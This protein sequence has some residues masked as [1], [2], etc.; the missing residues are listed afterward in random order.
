MSYQFDYKKEDTIRSISSQKALSEF[1][2]KNAKSLTRYQ[3]YLISKNKYFSLS[4]VD[5]EYLDMLDWEFISMGISLSIKEMEEHAG[6]LNWYCISAFQKLTIAFIEKYKDYLSLDVLLG[7]TLLDKE[8]E[9][10]AQ[11]TYAE[12]ND[13]QHYI[14]WR[15]N[16]LNAKTFRPKMPIQQNA[17]TAIELPTDA[18]ISKMQKA[19]A[20]LWLDKLQVRYLYKNTIAELRDMLQKKCNEERNSNMDTSAA[21]SYSDMLLQRIIRANRAEVKDVETIDY[22]NLSKSELK[23]ILDKRHIRYFYKDTLEILRDRC[24]R[25]DNG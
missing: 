25:S 16:L 7:N 17:G 5:G 21:D 14:I 1:L 8:T 12:N 2:A 11:K 20:K 6:Y 24:R 13:M 18:D 4:L 9:A 10:Y 19:D 22:S 23:K 3:W 15:D